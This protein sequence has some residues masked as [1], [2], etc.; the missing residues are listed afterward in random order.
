MEYY[1]RFTDTTTALPITGLTPTW[2]FLVKGSDGTAYTPQPV[3]TELG[4][5]VY[6]YPFVASE[7]IIGRVDG[8]VALGASYRYIDVQ[9]SITDVALDALIIPDYVGPV[10]VVPD[11]TDPDLQ[12]VHIYSMNGDGTEV[13]G[14]KVT[15]KPTENQVRNLVLISKELLSIVLDEQ[16][17]GYLVLIR[18]CEYNIDAP[19]WGEAR[20]FTVSNDPNQPLTYYL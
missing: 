8:G 9:M 4:N 19:W 18:G 5:G 16:G 12:F 11:N 13:A 10:M 3:I 17:Y 20:T 6:K 7:D 1:L 15:A 2:S 14:R